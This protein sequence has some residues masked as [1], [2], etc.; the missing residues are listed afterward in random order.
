MRHV[1]KEEMATHAHRVR[2][3]TPR[4]TEIELRDRLIVALDVPTVKEA[5]Y[6]V[7]KL[8]SSVNF[9]KIGLQL[10][11]AGGYEL[12]STLV[13]KGKKVFLDSKLWDIEQTI[14]NTVENVARIGATF[15]TVHGERKVIEAAVRG[16]GASELKILAVTFLTNLDEHDLKD[17]HISSSLDDFV[18]FRA[19]LAIS[20]GAD[21]V[22]ASAKEI[23]QIKEIAGDTLTIVSPGIRPVGSPPNDQ[24]RV[25]TPREAMKAGADYLVVGRPILEAVSM[26]RAVAK[27]ISEIETGLSDIAIAQ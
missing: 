22:I 8:G 1:A 7:A 12:A 5:E 23:A 11:S 2:T 19:K 15:L 25:A 16:R 18:V 10:Q 13:S 21:G 14:T 6:V 24:R 4:R 26:T 27:I 20:A 17:L 3:P 9:Y